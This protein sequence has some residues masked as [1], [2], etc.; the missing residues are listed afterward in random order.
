M[1]AEIKFSTHV[2]EPILAS[3]LNSYQKNIISDD[4][5]VAS[6]VHHAPIYKPLF[7]PSVET[8]VLLS[9]PILR[10]FLTA[11]QPYPAPLPSSAQTFNKLPALG[12]LEYGPGNIFFSFF[13]SRSC[14]S[15]S[16]RCRYVP[17]RR[18]GRTVF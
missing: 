2:R 7:S 4:V 10:Y 16:A 12:Q 11:R 18:A 8:S 3:T 9:F 1:D 5:I 6:L 15:L 13:A 17:G 14:P